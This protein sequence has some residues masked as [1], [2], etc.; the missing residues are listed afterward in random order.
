[1]TQFVS[2]ISCGQIRN[3]VVKYRVLTGKLLSSV[4]S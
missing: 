4:I 1:M 2:E 3:L